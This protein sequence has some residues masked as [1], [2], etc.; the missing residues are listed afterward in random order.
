[1]SRP[2]AGSSRSGD[3]PPGA[4]IAGFRLEGVIGRG[5]RATVYEATQ[6]SLD[7]RATISGPAR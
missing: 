4:L 2:G 1:M 7:R 3:L 6:L 5:S